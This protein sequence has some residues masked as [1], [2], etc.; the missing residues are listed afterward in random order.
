MYNIGD[1]TVD[2][3]RDIQ[4][5]WSF[6]KHR[7]YSL[8][9]LIDNNLRLIYVGNWS[10]FHHD[11]PHGRLLYNGIRAPNT[12][13]HSWRTYLWGGHSDPT[14]RGHGECTD[15]TLWATRRWHSWTFRI[16]SV[17]TK[18]CTIKQCCVQRSVISR[19]IDHHSWHHPTYGNDHERPV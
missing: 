12:Y 2:D 13:S 5:F 4:W 1:Q 16:S 10:S 17:A 9:N 18:I 3:V 14:Q 6:T 7:E 15:N 8:T 11:N 19:A